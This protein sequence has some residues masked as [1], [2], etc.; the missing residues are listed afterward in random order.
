MMGCGERGGKEVQETSNITYTYG[1]FTS[2]YGRNEHN[3]VKQQYANK[4]M[5]SDF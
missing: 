1:W 3:I 5:L 4:I 2:L